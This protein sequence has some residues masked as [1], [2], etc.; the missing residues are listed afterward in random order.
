MTLNSD[1]K[2]K[3]AALALTGFAAMTLVGCGGSSSS[4]TTAPGSSAGVVKIFGKAVKGPFKRNSTVTISRLN[5]N[6]TKGA[7]LGTGSVTAD[8]GSYE[9]GFS[10]YTGPVLV[11]VDGTYVDEATGTEKTVVSTA[12]VQSIAVAP[13]VAVNTTQNVTA[14][15]TPLTHMVVANVVESAK[16][17]P[18]STDDADLAKSFVDL[19]AQS[20]ADAFGLGDNFDVL[21]KEPSLESTD[22]STKSTAYGIILA[23]ISQLL[24]NE[25]NNDYASFATNSTRGILSVTDNASTGL[26][27]AV[28][29][30]LVS[31]ASNTNFTTVYSTISTDAL[32]SATSNIDPGKIVSAHQ[33]EFEKAL[34]AAST[35][36]TTAQ[37]ASITATMQTTG[38]TADAELVYTWSVGMKSSCPVVT[39]VSIPTDET[40]TSSAN[41]FG[42]ITV[43][44]ASISKTSAVSFWAAYAGEYS[45][46]LEV[47]RPNYKTVTATTNILVLDPHLSNFVGKTFYLMDE[48]STG[49]VAQGV[50][51]GKAAFGAD[52][53]LTVTEDPETVY[54]RTY[55]YASQGSLV[56]Q[57][58]QWHYSANTFYM[59]DPETGS[60]D[61]EMVST[62]VTDELGV[63]YISMGHHSGT[64]FYDTATERNNA[65]SRYNTLNAVVTSDD[66]NNKTYKM[67]SEN[68]TPV[69]SA[70]AIFGA[71]PGDLTIS[72]DITALVSVSPY[73]Y[74]ATTNTSNWYYHEE[75]VTY[76]TTT[77]TNR[78]VT[79]GETLYHSYRTFRKL[80]TSP[81]S[82]SY[83]AFSGG[84]NYFKLCTSTD[85]ACISA[86]EGTSQ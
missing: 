66:F 12:P 26:K 39:Y 57:T 58:G 3:V 17:I 54:N 41:H 28:T 36:M 53:I 20:I 71:G 48:D 52:R 22:D 49:G 34:V 55:T 9:I 29:S 84:G 65:V 11:E 64:R 51:V 79:V 4:T 61:S 78:I 82:V 62:N 13:T 75:Q 21:S 35:P 68:T 31:L 43:S 76:G 72:G 27:D 7:Q 44:A 19:R 70:T 30:A 69:T 6:G 77:S 50:A 18:I 33:H 16:N 56:T 40:A 2:R 45:V 73:S 37:T 24:E 38:T 63:N 23:G 10:N 14:H 5:A 67:Y 47:S 1:L 83:I 32:T 85:S 80:N 25:F 60:L 81:W 86:F 46:K 15:V 59:W 8:D 74:N 42:L